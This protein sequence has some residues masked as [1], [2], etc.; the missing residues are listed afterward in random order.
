[1]GFFLA[2]MPAMLSAAIPFPAGQPIP[3]S[4]TNHYGTIGS[5]K[6]GVS[7][8]ADVFGKGPYDLFVGLRTLYPFER[9]D[10]HSVPVYGNSATISSP[11]SQGYVFQ[12]ES[13]TYALADLGGKVCLLKFDKLKMQ[14]Q[15]FAAATLPRK[16]N[17][18]T[19]FIG[20]DQ[21]LHVF[22]T[23]GNGAGYYPTPD[24]HDPR[25]QPFNGSGIWRGGMPAD[26]VY[27]ARWATPEMKELE[28]NT[29]VKPEDQDAGLLFGCSG[30]AIAKFG[31]GNLQHRLIAANRLGVFRCY[32]NTSPTGMTFGGVAYAVDDTDANVILRHPIVNPQPV[33]IPNPRTGFSDLI[34][35]DSGRMWHYPFKG[36]FQN[37]SPIY[38]E[39][40]PLLAAGQDI[41]LGALPVIS[42]GDIDRDGRI[43]FIAGNDAGELLFIK[44]IGT[45]DT[46]DFANPVEILVDGRNYRERGGYRGSIQGPGEANWDYTCPTLYDWNLDGK[47]DIIMNSINGNLVVL[48]QED[49]KSNPPKFQT[50]LPMFDNSL[51]L[52][53]SWRTQPGITTWGG[54]TAPC[55]IAND[56]ENRLRL[57]YRIDN[58]N[59]KRGPV[60]KLT[61]GEEIQAHDKR[62]GGQF[63][64]SK[65][66]PVD[67][68]H[69]GQIDLI[70][71]TG[72]AM[73]L[74][75]PGGIPDNLGGDER[76]ASVL[77]L[78]NAGS[79]Q[80]PKFEYPVRIAY[81][82]SA[83]KMGTHSCSPAAVN[84][85]GGP[86]LFV[87][88][89]TG[90]I[91]YYPRGGLR[92]R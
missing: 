20:A 72:R 58:Q 30:M 90:R 50:P 6:G 82:G 44:N 47:L 36:M 23:R 37:D 27:Y 24:S 73:S 64:R 55:M 75:G 5:R 66:V 11:A 83:I 38:G 31:S 53:L 21:K 87:A 12:H 1:M 41:I 60:L 42:P 28:I 40:R 46:P 4:G 74:P 48:L 3:A 33:P 80:E 88:E 51:D 16:G 62:Y 67:W 70:I 9:F 89:E 71:G 45:A 84:F 35:S 91:F 22:Y 65:I 68:D 19:G 78:R 26:Q 56:E 8:T 2:T 13:G 61:T 92:W 14:F 7:V 85:G 52:H 59:V 63:G 54:T 32:V 77:F 15:Q 18:L 39:R 81:D 25:Y 10:A 17:N 29:P 86:D 49:G 57:F 69:D 76:R 34:V 79:N 43:D